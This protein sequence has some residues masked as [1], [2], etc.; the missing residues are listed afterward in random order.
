MAKVTSLHE[1][2]TGSVGNITYS[3]VKGGQHVAKRK[4]IT[5]GGVATLLQLTQRGRF[6]VIV[7]LARLFLTFLAGNYKAKL[8]KRSDYNQFVSL[9]TN[10]ITE[11]PTGDYEIAY[12]DLQIFDIQE[13]KA[14]GAGATIVSG[15]NSKA[16]ITFA[17]NYTGNGLNAIANSKVKVIAINPDNNQIGKYVVDMAAVGSQVVTHLF[18]GID[19]GQNIILFVGYYDEIRHRYFAI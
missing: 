12:P 9:N 7:A 17:Y 16:E 13:V 2:A 15:V 19:F 5:Q 11:T 14:N 6:G 18:E 3:K 8:A 10:T 1:G 4:I